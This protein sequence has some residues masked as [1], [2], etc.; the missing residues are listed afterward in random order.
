MIQYRQP[1][2]LI[3]GENRPRGNCCICGEPISGPP[4]KLVCG[5]WACLNARMHQLK[6]RAMKARSMKI[7]RDK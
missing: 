3:A 4:N 2:L 5:K 7:E 6:T 1:G